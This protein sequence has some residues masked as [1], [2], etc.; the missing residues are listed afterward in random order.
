MTDT[1]ET[2]PG[3]MAR[4]LAAKIAEAKRYAAREGFSVSTVSA[5]PEEADILI[6][7]LTAI[8]APEAQREGLFQARVQPWMMACFGLEISG[9]REERNHRFLEEA[10]E[11]VQACGCTAGEAHQLVEYVY[12]RPV[13]EK[14]Q[15]VGGVMVT[16]AAL[17][18]ANDLDMHAEAETELARI[19]TKGPREAGREK[20]RPPPSRGWP[21]AEAE[22]RVA[23]RSSAAAP[24]I[25][26]WPTRFLA[27]LRTAAGGV[28]RQ[29]GGT[30]REGQVGLVRGGISGCSCRRPAAGEGNPYARLPD[31]LGK[32]PRHAKELVEMAEE[33]SL[34]AQNRLVRVKT[35]NGIKIYDPW[36][37]SAPRIICRAVIAQAETG[38]A[39][40]SE[41]GVER[42]HCGCPVTGKH[43]PSCP[44]IMGDI[45]R[46]DASSSEPSQQGVEAA[47]LPFVAAIDEIETRWSFPLSDGVGCPA[48][49]INLGQ[50]RALRAALS[51][52]STGS[53]ER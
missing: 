41:P 46:R 27:A 45:A 2:V 35:D 6:A 29:A 5:S 9:D 47:A 36:F 53:A 25:R 44:T 20:I 40:A 11:L 19:W 39:R 51:T 24:C 50:L 1:T 49:Y 10:L 7:A 17:C 52:P 31:F 21:A 16:L 3:A 14:G 28:G 38:K 8:S 23:D 30:E 13:G 32:F 26:L 22:A 42:Y 18:L 34:D 43:L 15:E 4:D 48:G 37:P 12:G 33:L